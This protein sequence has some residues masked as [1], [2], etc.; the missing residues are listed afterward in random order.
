VIRFPFLLLCASLFLSGPGREADGTDPR[1]AVEK[2]G[3]YAVL[4]QAKTP[5]KGSEED[6]RALVRRIFLG[7][8]GRWPGG[9]RA[10]P[11]D[12]A[13][14]ADMRR[15]F[16]REVLGMTEG[17]WYRHWLLKKQ[18]RGAT[19]PRRFASDFI[20]FHMIARHPGAIGYAKL[21][22]RL[23]RKLKVLFRFGGRKKKAAPPGSFRRRR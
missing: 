6:A 18:K 13:N 14:R 4:I 10:L 8:L 21:P 5:W 22:A 11:Y 16:L 23:P 1:P 12:R 7:E 19:P 15:A 20:L 2:E 17:A 9:I 3:P